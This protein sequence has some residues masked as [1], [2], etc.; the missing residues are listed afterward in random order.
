MAMRERVRRGLAVFRRSSAN[1]RSAGSE[2]A[3]LAVH[4]ADP[5]HPRAGGEESTKMI[6]GLDGVAPSRNIEGPERA[7]AERD[8]VKAADSVAIGTVAL[9]RKE[10]KTVSPTWLAMTLMIVSGGVLAFVA[11][12]ELVEDGPSS[13]RA[14]GLSDGL[15]VAAAVTVGA[16]AVASGLRRRLKRS[17]SVLGAAALA[18]AALWVDAVPPNE[19]DS[20]TSAVPVV[21]S[22]SHTPSMNESPITEPI[23][24]V[25]RFLKYPPSGM[26]GAC[27]PGREDFALAVAGTWSAPQLR[28]FSDY[29][30][31]PTEMLAPT[32]TS[33]PGPNVS[34]EWNAPAGT[35]AIWRIK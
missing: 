20:P 30:P 32:R 14:D 6:S 7:V 18:A 19:L 13:L 10:E 5:T 29:A 17:I 15:L 25:V 2:A 9:A 8:D 33:C 12:G 35:V 31:K 3:P 28:F 24:V 27:V 16:G 21:A 11:A 26:P 22:S 4:A 1:D 34:W 23:P